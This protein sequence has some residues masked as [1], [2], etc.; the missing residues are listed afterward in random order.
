MLSSV[1]SVSGN[2][3]DGFAAACDR[4]VHPS[5]E[6]PG[7]RSRH[8]RLIG[9]LLGAPFLLAG[10]ISQVFY[11]SIENGL[12]LGINCAIFA[13][14][15]IAVAIV[16]ATARTKGVE[17]T[18]LLIGTFV[19]GLVVSVTGLLSSPLVLLLLAP[20][21]E[22]WWLTRSR[23]PSN[24]GWWAS[25]GVCAVA[26]AAIGGGYGGTHAFAVH[27]WVLPLIYAVSMWIRFTNP[28]ASAADETP[29][30]PNLLE[31]AAKI[32]GN[33]V[34]R[35]NP[36]GEIDYATRQSAETIGVPAS[37]LLGTGLFERIHV[38]DRV[39]YLTLVSDTASDGQRR[40]AE[41]RLR[42]P[43]DGE[44]PLHGKFHSLRFEFTREDQ[45]SN[46]VLV[47]VKECPE[48][49]QLRDAATQARDRAD[50]MEITKGRFLASVSHELRTPLNAIIG[51]AE[52]LKNEMFGPLPD[53]RQ[54]EYVEL[55][56]QSGNHL[57]S[58]V[59]A[60]LDVSKIESGNYLIEP[61]PFSFSDALEMCHSMMV[62][63]AKAKDIT[64]ARD[65]DRSVDEIVADRRAIQQI[66]INLVSNAIKFTPHG[67]RI[68]VSA[69]VKKDRLHFRVTDNGIGIAAEDLERIGQP[70]IQVQNDY[71]RQYEGTGLG[72]SLVKGL[73]ALH[74]GEMSIDSAPDCGTTVAISLPLAGPSSTAEVP[75]FEAAQMPGR[76]V[77]DKINDAERKQA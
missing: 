1:N 18:S 3:Q 56:G 15:W 77:E 71:T 10:L 27:F 75:E 34:F 66:L 5:V 4:L 36:K 33:A 45:E 63:Q 43:G 35:A 7:A 55:I 61:E 2:W 64:I 68:L 48:I 24:V 54:K 74:E 38:A 31:Q 29:S 52:M 62:L 19:I 21:F 76:E 57:L 16:S 11:G 26:M 6:S 53:P 44:A 73:V 47:A 37:L 39:D 25:I 14:S 70:F 28:A 8:R 41:L 58:V 50:S 65:V 12:L 51:F 49:T 20:P 13:V 60:I 30:A 59:N 32:G 42:L 67:G 17:I 23:G 22:S 40:S 9:L 69:E 46:I 72:L